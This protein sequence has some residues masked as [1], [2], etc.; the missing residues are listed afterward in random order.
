M[1]TWQKVR[2]RTSVWTLLFGFTAGMQ[3]FRQAYPDA[4][5]FGFFTVV[6]ALES[7]GALHRWKF[8][9]VKVKDATAIALALF[10]ALFIYFSHR[11]AV[12]LLIFLIALGF[13]L[14]AATWRRANDHE[15][16]SNLQ[17]RSAIYWGIVATALGLWEFCAMFF[18]TLA[19]EDKFPT[20][21]V[22]F[23]PKLESPLVKFQFIA[24][25]LGLGLYFFE[26]WKH[27]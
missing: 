26:R 14:F 25:W 4:V 9:G 23:L 1:N 13:M 19:H 10:S 5:I 7:S 11:Q 21:S 27:R 12:T 2:E 8:S 24:L 17:F 22:I 6:L 16:L 20:L 3:V 15:K 18:S